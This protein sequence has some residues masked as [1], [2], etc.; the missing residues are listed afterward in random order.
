[1]DDAEASAQT[2]ERSQPTTQ[3]QFFTKKVN[4]N[5]YDRCSYKLA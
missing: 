2:A 5:S 4:N 3:T 1:M